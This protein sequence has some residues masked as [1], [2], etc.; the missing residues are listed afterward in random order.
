MPKK[1]PPMAES[2]IRSLRHVEVNGQPAKKPWFVGHV[3]I[4]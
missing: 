1:L 2:K 3:A 4:P